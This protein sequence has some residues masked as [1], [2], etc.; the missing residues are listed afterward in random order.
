MMTRRVLTL[1]AIAFLFSFP[2][3][4]PAAASSCEVP[5]H[6][7][8]TYQT[9]AVP[10]A[11][12]TTPLAINERGDVVGS[13]TMN[14]V[15]F[16]FLWSNGTYTTIAV[17]GASGTT[18]TDINA[19]G[20][21]VGFTNTASFRLEDGAFTAIDVPGSLATLALG[22]NNAG[23]VVGFAL[24][25]NDF[26]GIEAGFVL[27]RGV[28]ERVV[29]PA[30]QGGTV[31]NDINARGSVLGNASGVGFFVLNNSGFAVPVV[32]EPVDAIDT[33]LSRITDRGG[34]VGTTYLPSGSTGF[35]YTNHSYTLFEYPGAQQTRVT[36]ANSRGLVVGE[37]FDGVGGQVGFL[38]VP[39]R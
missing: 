39:R 3:A 10:G 29:H 8:G 23:E 27:R 13:Y 4:V 7:Q 37:A 21:I 34:Y 16:G 30:A 20:T 36:D 22:I 19:K 28:F 26:D 9:L 18:A 11:E 14:G 5:A 1:A 38:F 2:A 17:P 25:P 12:T 35:V 15:S 33:V 6:A 24:E 32:C 31:L